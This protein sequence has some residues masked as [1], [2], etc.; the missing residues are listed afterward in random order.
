[1]LQELTRL[2]PVHKLVSEDKE[3]FSS[4]MYIFLKLRAKIFSWK[5][6][7]SNNEAMIK[8]SLRVET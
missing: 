6:N 4:V 8:K 7:E 1:M 3:Y 5:E 2:S